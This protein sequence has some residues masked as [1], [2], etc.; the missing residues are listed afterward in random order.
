MKEL[1]N[2]ILYRLKLKKRP[3]LSKVDQWRARGV[4][5]GENFD[6]PDSAIDYCFGHLVTMFLLAMVVLSC[7]A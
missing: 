7:R 3:A 6:A 2:R 5:I 4:T 1:L